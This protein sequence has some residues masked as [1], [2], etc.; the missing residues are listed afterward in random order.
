MMYHT[1][2]RSLLPYHNR[3]VMFDP[4]Y[5]EGDMHA[6]VK[7]DW[8]SMYGDVKVLLPSGAPTPW[9]RRLTCACV[10]TMVTLMISSQGVQGLDL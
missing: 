5:L 6:F 2:V 3:R 4:T 8:K 9:G 1:F 10:L 7:I